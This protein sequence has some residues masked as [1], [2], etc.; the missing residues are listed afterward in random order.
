[1]RLF[2][3]WRV[4]DETGVSGAGFVAEG[5]Q[6]SDDSCVMR[7]RTAHTSTA[8]YASLKDVKAIHGH[9]GNTV[10]MYEDMDLVHR[11]GQ[12]VIFDGCQCFKPLPGGTEELFDGWPGSDYCKI[13]EWLKM[14]PQPTPTA[15]KGE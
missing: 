8:F 3:L 6:F 11:S 10:V 2:Y 4:V 9:H 15:G 1:M 7:W 5:C 12:A 13:G 14:H